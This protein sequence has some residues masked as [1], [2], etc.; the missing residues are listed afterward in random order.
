MVRTQPIT[1]D[2][3]DSI[4]TDIP[5]MDDG[6]ISLS[7]ALEA[8]LKKVADPEETTGPFDIPDDELAYNQVKLPNGDVVTMREET[9]GDAMRV[10]MTLQRIGCGQYEMGQEGYTNCKVI[11]GIEDINGR[12]FQ[13]P[14][15]RQEMLYVGDQIKGRVRMMLIELYA[16]LNSGQEDASGTGNFRGRSQV[17]RDR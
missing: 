12:P 11:M 14:R 8:R 3:N 6:G 13:K 5:T 2:E 9:S 16:R 17:A 1:Q 4:P 15:N 7:S 10:S